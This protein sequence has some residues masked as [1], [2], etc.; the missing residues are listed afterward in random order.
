MKV[1]ILCGGYGSRLDNLGKLI[2]KPMVRIGK[3]PLLFHIIENF[4]NQG[5]Q[6]FVLCTGHKEET[7]TNFFLKEKKIFIIKKIKKSKKHIFFQYKN[8]KLEF[9]CNVVFTGSSTATGGRIKIAYEK[10]RIKEDFIMTYGDGL[11]NVNLKKLI[12]FH[13]KKK[14][15]ITM[16]AVNP[17]H[18][19]GILN[20]KNSKVLS[21]DDSKS[22]TTN[23]YINGGFFV[24]SSEAI[25]NIKKNKVFWEKEPL[26]HA[27]K[28]KK[29]FAYMHKSFWHSVDTL[30][31]LKEI[32]N[33]YKKGKMP[34]KI[35]AKRF[36]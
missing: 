18:K 14:S 12:N 16:T 10:L 31:D 25:N 22:K 9:N 19:Y 5:F 30:K 11:A 21:F 20:I 2:A 23:H 24:I 28:N 4:A 33:F 7:I 34:W 6:D 26:T 32:N 13:Y 27:I 17:K 15:Y 35:N 29:V 3:N 36:K 1:F 8:K